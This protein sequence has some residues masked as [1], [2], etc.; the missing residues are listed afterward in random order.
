MKLGRD[1]YLD[2]SRKLQ[3]AVNVKVFAFKAGRRTPDARVCLGTLH[4]PEDYFRVLRAVLQN[5]LRLLGASVTVGGS[6]I[7]AQRDE[8]AADLIAPADLRERA[9]ASEQSE[10]FTA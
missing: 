5:G 6:Y 7:A 10:A 4:M 2:V 1:L 8:I 3:G 9:A